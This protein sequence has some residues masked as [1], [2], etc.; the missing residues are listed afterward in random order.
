MG[1]YGY[2]DEYKRSHNGSQYTRDDSERFDE[3]G[4]FI[5]YQP[6]EEELSKK[7]E[8]KKALEEELA[9]AR[10]HDPMDDY[11]GID[12]TEYREEHAC[13]DVAKQFGV[14]QDFVEDIMA[15]L[16][17]EF[18]ANQFKEIEWANTPGNL[19]PEE[20][21]AYMMGELDISDRIT[22]SCNGKS[23]KDKK[24]KKAVKSNKQYFVQVNT[25]DMVLFDTLQDANKSYI[26]TVSNSGPEDYITIG[27]TDGNKIMQ[28]DSARG[29]LKNSRAVKSGAGYPT[30]KSDIGDV[31]EA[32]RKY[33]NYHLPSGAQSATV[34]KVKKVRGSEPCWVAD[35]EY[36]Y[37]YQNGENLTTIQQEEFPCDSEIFVYSS[38]T[39]KSARVTD[40]YQ[41][42]LNELNVGNILNILTNVFRDEREFSV[43]REE[44]AASTKSVYVWKTRFPEERF[45]VSEPV[46]RADIFDNEVR[47]VPLNKAQTVLPENTKWQSRTLKE[48]ME[49]AEDAKNELVMSFNN[50][51]T[52]KSG[53]D[54]SG[55]NKA[56]MLAKMA[57]EMSYPNNPDYKRF[58]E[59]FN[60][61]RGAYKALVQLT[62]D[63]E[64][65]DA[66]QDTL[67]YSYDTFKGWIEDDLKQICEW[68]YDRNFISRLKKYSPQ[69][70]DD[71]VEKSAQLV[72]D[73]LTPIN[74]SRQIKSAWTTDNPIRDEG[75]DACMAGEQKDTNPYK[76]G[77]TEQFESW[78]EGWEAAYDEIHGRGIGSSKQIKSSYPKT[79]KQNKFNWSYNGWIGRFVDD[80]AYTDRYLEGVKWFDNNKSSLDALCKEYDCYPVSDNEKAAFYN[81][82]REVGEITSSK[83][84][85]SSVSTS[86]DSKK[87][88]KVLEKKIPFYWGKGSFLDKLF[89][90]GSW[91]WEEFTCP[92]YFGHDRYN[93]TPDTDVSFIIA[94]GHGRPVLFLNADVATDTVWTITTEK[95]KKLDKSVAIN[96]YEGLANSIINNL[97]SIKPNWIKETIES[98]KDSLD[99][100]KEQS[101]SYL[102]GLGDWENRYSNDSYVYNRVK[103]NIAKCEK[104]IENYNTYYNMFDSAT[105]LSSIIKSSKFYTS[106][107]R[108]KY[109][110]AVLP[111]SKATVMSFFEDG[112]WSWNDTVAIVGNVESG[113]IDKNGQMASRPAVIFGANSKYSDIEK[114]TG[115]FNDQSWNDIGYFSFQSYS[116]DSS[117]FQIPGARY[118]VLK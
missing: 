65:A 108:W 28:Y 82:L 7:D 118:F 101:E 27:E 79:D 72:K 92:D 59:D 30:W 53:A 39:V 68:E 32:I 50:A 100:N 21:E 113:R 11:A 49:D 15:E 38:R 75:W 80:L 23:K 20:Y 60:N 85:K 78:K 73:N 89:G 63:G 34:L 6:T 115:L 52:V 18:A 13:E 17:N 91:M 109:N 22:S 42:T 4:E 19:T 66:L 105:V 24:K 81:A 102:N 64:H 36:S 12:T 57:N 71:I 40:F 104:D 86:F 29:V 110:K 67:N 98:F 70:W 43:Y 37:G 25:D 47:M 16:D 1:R 48:F 62:Y 69:A 88:Y 103:Q 41:K 3:V 116:N 14:D 117:V 26:Q 84:I 106:Y 111:V 44:G 90:K 9:L 76:R 51:S 58:M 107:G 93:P 31:T 112:T 45:S 77:T 33:C 96:D 114:G 8:I 95:G 54:Y 61:K 10:E 5:P 83:Q 56:K 94:T 46:L 74:N 55:E 87:F 35:V 2:P 97:N 99:N